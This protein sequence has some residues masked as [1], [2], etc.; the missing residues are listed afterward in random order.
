[1]MWAPVAVVF[2]PMTLPSIA[3]GDSIYKKAF[4]LKPGDNYN[5]ALKYFETPYKVD[6]R[7]TNYKIVEYNLVTIKTEGAKLYMLLG[8]MNEKIE[9]IIYGGSYY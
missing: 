4:S 2:L 6:N 7:T 5:T 9:W 8:V 1:M 3:R